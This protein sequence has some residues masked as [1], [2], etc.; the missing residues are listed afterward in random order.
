M[1]TVHIGRLTERPPKEGPNDFGD[2]S[3]TTNA[4]IA[5]QLDT[6]TTGS[7]RCCIPPVLCGNAGGAF[8]V[9]LTFWLEHRAW[10]CT[11]EPEGGGL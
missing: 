7:E 2:E 6:T 5:T 8:C 1:L 3:L 10:A 4:C 9:F 11:V